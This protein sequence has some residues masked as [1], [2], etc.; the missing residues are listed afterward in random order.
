MSLLLE[1]KADPNIRTLAAES[2]S[3]LIKET[4]KDKA[5]FV[6]ED[7]GM[8]DMLLAEFPLRVGSGATPLVMA[9]Q[10]SDLHAAA[11][12]IQVYLCVCV[13]VCVFV[14]LCVCVCVCVCVRVGNV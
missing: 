7:F 11:I 13:P 5:F 4:L 8:E 3:T 9:V 14:S 6:H 12:L 10:N 2:R 1:H